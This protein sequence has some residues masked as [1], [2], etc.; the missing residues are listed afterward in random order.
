VDVVEPGDVDRRVAELCDRLV[1]NAPVTMRVAKEAVRRL[2]HAGL[3]D[4]GDL[5]RAC[6]GS[7]DFREGVR[8]FIDKREPQ[9]SGR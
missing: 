6:Y 5:V 3:P 7:D 8:A 9:W 2:L 1:H 4:D